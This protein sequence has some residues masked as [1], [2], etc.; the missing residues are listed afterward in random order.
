VVQPVAT[1][2]EHEQPLPV[3]EQPAMAKA[4]LERLRALEVQILRGANT[5]RSI[6]QSNLRTVRP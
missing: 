1:Y 6:K 5:R 2:G 3:A 4:E